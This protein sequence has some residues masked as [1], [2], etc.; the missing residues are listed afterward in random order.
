[1]PQDFREREDEGLALQ[2]RRGVVGGFQD[3]LLGRRRLRRRRGEHAVIGFIDDPVD[4]VKAVDDRR[5][6][7]GQRGF[8]GGQRRLLANVR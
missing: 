7:D 2:V 5:L 3:H 4:G 6:I 8:R 1:M